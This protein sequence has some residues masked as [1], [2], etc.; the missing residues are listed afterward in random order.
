MSQAS[1]YPSI[2]DY[3]LISDM[4]SCAL[5]STSGSIDW[6]CFPRFDDAAVF[7][8]IL[9]WDKGGYFK[10]SPD[11][12]KSTSRHYLNDTNILE[13]TFE[14]ETG[15]AKLTDFMP[16]H[17]HP[18]AQTPRELRDD[19]Q[20]MRILECTRGSIAYTVE[21]V[22][23]F[24][25]GTI[26]PHAHLD[27]ANTAFA[28]GGSDAISFYCSSTIELL[29]DGFISRGTLEQGQNICAVVTYESHF[30]HEV[31]RVD[32]DLVKELLE[33]TRQYWNDWSDICTYKGEY[34][35]VVIRSALTL[36][37]LTYAPSGGM[38]AAAT[39]SLPEVIGGPRNWDY[40]YA[41]IRDASFAL[42]GL[43]ILG[44]TKEAVAFKDWLEWAT[45]GRARDL[46]I[47]YGLGGERRL[48]EVELPDLAG[49]KHSRPVRVGNGA[50]GQ[51][52]LDV[53]GELV[54]SV[55]LYR[56]Y[57]GA[58]DDSQWDY[59]LRVIAYVLDHWREPDEGVWEARA[60][61]QHYVF[62]KA[63]CWVALQRAVKM[64]N[65]LNLPGDV[66]HWS[67]VRDE[68]K[69]DILTHG[70]DQERGVF[71]QAYG[72]KILDAGNLILP[73][74]GFIKAK[75]PRM[76]A[77]IRAIQKELASP[78]GFIYRYRGF[79]D[80][81]AGDE[82]TFNICTFWLCDNLILLGELDEATELF[83]K[84]LAHANDLGLMSEQISASGGEMLGNYPQAFSHLSIINTAVQLQKA[85]KKRGQKNR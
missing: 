70:F 16:V 72:S 64:A 71:V 60:E 68:I 31:D 69:A 75:D 65:D 36:K 32:E 42:Y 85:A 30:A 74:I 14:T 2:S 29:D 6:C 9:D 61:R 21:C 26:V 80:G 27:T 22:P 40:R 18:T 19:H 77:T 78:D 8:R 59:L 28:H 66:E 17:D 73:L 12:V 25:Y 35:E 67:Q 15:T 83:N 49:Y 55:H 23:R 46:Q 38:V 57:V 54:D 84:L 37:A 51:F 43:F 45:V 7:S 63:W 50:Y 79:D 4:H 11:G 24:D 39:T 10:V 81:L 5:V 20:V 33:E 52:Q 62:S 47:M 58:I 76:L 82:G 56:K 53:Y 44:Y 1:D 13:T 34:R 48:T 3:G 41:W